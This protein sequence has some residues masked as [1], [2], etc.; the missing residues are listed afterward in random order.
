MSDEALATTTA[1]AFTDAPPD[2]LPPHLGGSYREGD[3]NTWMPDVWGY[4]LVRYNVKSMIDIGC[5]WGHTMEWV[6]KMLVHAIGFDGDHSCISGNK[7]FGNAYLHDF[8]VGPPSPSHLP[9]NAIYDLAWSSEFLEHVEERY[10]DNYFAVF[11][12]CRY[13]VITH[14]E[15]GQH[16]H[17]H[18]NCQDDAYWVQRFAE[19]GFIHVPDET[20]LLRK[21]DR[22]SAGWGRRTLM[23]FRRI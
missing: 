23:F 3:G 5:G 14:A 15:P 18:V 13:A 20:A 16:G 6:N 8:T 21:T 12:Q 4:L 22:W 17:H 7:C 19:A 11:R 1:P 9:T 10:A 2:R